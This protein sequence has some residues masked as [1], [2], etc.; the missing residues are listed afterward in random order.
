MADSGGWRRIVLRNR[1]IATAGL[2]HI[3]LV[4]MLLL[5]GSVSCSKEHEAP[6]AFHQTLLDTPSDVE[7]EFVVARQR[8]VLSWTIVDETNVTGYVVSLS[9]STS[10]LIQSLVTEKTYTVEE[11]SLVAEGFVGETWVYY[12]V[13]AVDEQLFRGPASP[14]DSLLVR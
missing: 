11:S 7:A 4:G 10:L 1:E 2:W 6:V 14:V 12:Q 3:L 8:I 5:A 13:S 9:D